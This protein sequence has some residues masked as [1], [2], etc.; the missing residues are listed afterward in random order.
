MDDYVI[1]RTAESSLR[2]NRLIEAWSPQEFR[3][4]YRP[5]TEKFTPWAERL[6]AGTVSPAEAFRAR[7]ELMDAWRAFPWSDPD[8]PA[9]L[10]PEAWPRTEAR[11]LLVRLYDGLADAA[12]AY[13]EEIVAREA[14]EL[15]GTAQALSVAPGL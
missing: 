1:F 7:T 5:L 6:D 9:E 15:A 13:V 4:Q 14:P 12:T 8:L 11:E 2:G 10:L 3:E